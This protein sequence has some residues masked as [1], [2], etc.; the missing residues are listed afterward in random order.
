MLRQVVPFQDP[1]TTPHHC[2]GSACPG[3]SW[4]ASHYPHPGS[5]IGPRD[6]TLRSEPWPTATD[7][8]PADQDVP[9]TCN[10]PALTEILPNAPPTPLVFTYTN[11]RGETSTR[12]VALDPAPQVRYID[13]PHHGPDC[14]LTGFD[15]DHGAMRDFALDHI[16]FQAERGKEC[17]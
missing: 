2:R 11:H 6:V 9:R 12:R 3:L 5:C 1:G 15:L 7:A 8:K 10:A 16:L 13:S 14:V 4:R 17:P